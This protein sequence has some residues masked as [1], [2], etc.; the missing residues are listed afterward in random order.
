[1]MLK[2]L[3][4]NVRGANNLEKRK[5]IRNFVR[6]QMVDLAC[7]QETK[8]QD[9]SSTYAYSFGVGKFADWK[10][11]EAKGTTGGILLFWDRRKLDLV[12]V[13]TSLFSIVCPFKIVEDRFQWAFTG[14]YGLVEKSKR[15]LF[16]VRVSE[17]PVGGSL[18]P[19]RRLQ[20]DSFPF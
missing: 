10:A 4:W 15:E 5:I 17:R 14:V 20:C 13:E 2:F 19:T 11:L 16:W 3:S 12:E 6:L 1:M 18:M 7:L 9:F 8:I